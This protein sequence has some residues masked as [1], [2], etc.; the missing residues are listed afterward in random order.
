MGF[1]NQL[2]IGGAGYDDPNYGNG[3]Q[4]SLRLSIPSLTT[5]QVCL[6]P[7]HCRKLI[8]GPKLSNMGPTDGTE[9]GPT[10]NYHTSEQNRI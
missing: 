5:S 10:Q 6:Q 4:L 7:K 2:I 8:R 3:D 1:I 9:K